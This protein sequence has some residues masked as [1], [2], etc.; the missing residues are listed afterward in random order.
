MSMRIT[1]TVQFDAAHFLPAPGTVTD[2][3][4]RYERLHG[5]SFAL[6]VTIEG[7]PAKDTAF[8]AD[9]AKVETALEA[10]RERLDHHLLNEIPGL[11]R[12]TLENISQWVAN[13]LQADFPGLA[14]VTVARPSIGEECTLRVGR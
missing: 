6:S 12:P 5:H 3:D 1:K 10:L 9:F 11:E 14:E 13:K 8:V 2:Y 7:T 4:P